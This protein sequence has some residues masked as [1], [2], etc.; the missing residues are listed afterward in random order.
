MVDLSYGAISPFFMSPFHI[1][2]FS[3]APPGRMGNGL[4]AP[5]SGRPDFRMR[6]KPRAGGKILPESLSLLKRLIIH[7]APETQAD[8]GKIHPTKKSSHLCL[9]LFPGIC[10]YREEDRPGHWFHSFPLKKVRLKLNRAKFNSEEECICQ[11]EWRSKF[12][13]NDSGPP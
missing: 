12:G 13:R 8:G 11:P 7:R 10:P 4:F 2:T 5:S 3:A 1:Q 6:G 9:L